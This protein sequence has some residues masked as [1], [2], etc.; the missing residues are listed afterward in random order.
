[1]TAR[2]RAFIS[3]AHSDERWARWLQ[4]SLERYRAPK[5][6][7]QTVES[8]EAGSTRLFPIFR[9][10]D[11]LASSADLSKSI[12]DALQ[13][14]DAL[15][16]VCSPAAANSKWVNEEVRQFRQLGRESKIFCLLV[17]GSPDPDSDE[18]AFPEALLRA[19]D[20]S[21]LA[22]PLAADV[23]PD[24]DG[25][26]GAMLKIAA[27]LLGVGIDALKQRDAQRQLRRRTLVAF[28]SMGVAVVTLA[29][30]VVAFIA[31]EE[32][33]IRRGQAEG[34]YRG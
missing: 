2:Y 32:A 20:G 28:S 13:R 8:D 19:D 18:C 4:S 10:R 5:Q 34:E 25:K 11:E 6:V 9:D 14:S 16:V 17:D 22:E 15:I 33:E 30:A 1:M 12:Q 26:R 27:S 3:Y 24:G 23:S 21:V 31:R 29:L 7:I